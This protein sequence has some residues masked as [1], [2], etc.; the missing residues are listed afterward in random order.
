MTEAIVSVCS[1]LSIAFSVL[2]LIVEIWRSL[3]SKKRQTQKLL[4]REN[5]KQK[6]LVRARGKLIIR[7]IISIIN[8][9][10]L[11]FITSQLINLAKFD[12][13]V[14]K[15]N[16]GNFLSAQEIFMDLNEYTLYMRSRY[17]Y[18]KQLYDSGNTEDAALIFAELGDYGDSRQYL[19]LIEFADLPNTDLNKVQEDTY[20]TAYNFYE[21]G[22]Y[23]RALIYFRELSDYRD[24]EELANECLQMMRIHLA[25]TISAGIR[26][27]VGI[28]SDGTVVSTGNRVLY[29][30]HDWTDIMS[31]SN[32]GAITIGLKE[33]GTVISTGTYSVDLST[34]S[35]VIAVSA[36]EQYVIG[37]K[38]DG[39]VLGAGHDAGDNQLS[40]S[41]WT[42]IIA[43]ATGWRHTVGLDINGTVFITGYGASKQLKEIDTNHSQWENIIAIAAGGGN[44]AGKGHT[45]GLRADGKVV[46]VGDN[47]YGQCNVEGWDNIV[48]I[49]AGDWHTIGLCANG[50][51]VSTCPDSARY[52]D[53]Y[54][55][56]CDV[57]DW[58]DIVQIAA[59]SG[60]TLG[61]RSDGFV[62]AVGYNDEGKSEEVKNWSSIKLID[63]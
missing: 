29:D 44:V 16:N 5:T 52:P 33:D 42:D 56:A 61:L 6:K 62:V 2:A 21:K 54:S 48:A 25:H 50:T 51:V 40:V 31:I 39:T 28:R 30:Y 32:K 57:D 26:S 59:G 22:Q 55:G 38:S 4:I 23:S 36:G 12:I 24:S 1:I 14:N 60:Y 34:W 58:T 43:I 37:L 53:L 47:T 9:I 15:M 13:A 27:S 8:C 35:D 3:I 7:L 17:A 18:A 19:S 49:A 41:S 46:A 11:I 45:V 63:N 20:A 10:A